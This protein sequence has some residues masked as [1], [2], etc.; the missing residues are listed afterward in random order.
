M[1]IIHQHE[2]G[3]KKTEKLS[4]LFEKRTL[5]KVKSQLLDGTKKFYQNIG[6]SF[7]GESFTRKTPTEYE[8][9]IWKHYGN[10]ALI[11]QIENTG[12]ILLN[13][14]LLQSSS[15]VKEIMKNN[16]SKNKVPV[17]ILKISSSIDFTIQNKIWNFPEEKLD[18]LK[19]S[20]NPSYEDVY[21]ALL[22]LYYVYSWKDTETGRGKIFSPKNQDDY[23]YKK[24]LS[25]YAVIMIH[26]MNSKPLSLIISQSINYYITE[27]KEIYNK[28][29]QESLGF[30]KENNQLHINTL[31]NNILNDIDYIL[32][33][34][35]MRYFDNHYRILE[36]KLGKEQ[37]G[38]NWANFLEYGSTTKEIIEL[39]NLGFPRNLASMLFKDFYSFLKRNLNGEVVEVEFLEILPA[40]Y[41]NKKYQ[42][43]ADFYEQYYKLSEGAN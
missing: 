22:Q 11:Q 28:Q 32:R 37:A 16:V 24:I 19:L 43:L 41:G 7:S 8:Q 12:S 2:L 6:N 18:R 27:N 29:S 35:I 21:G 4:G 40:I 23:V 34:R 5:P 10:I 20:Y 1:I 33:F 13:K 42:E 9:E 31:I 14:L 15:E 3:W 17:E 30:F 39:Q 26:W 38:A 36:A 25:Y